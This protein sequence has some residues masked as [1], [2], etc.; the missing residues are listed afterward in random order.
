[1]C[2]VIGSTFEGANVMGVAVA[3]G[4]WSFAVLRYQELDATNWTG[5]RLKGVDF[6][7]ASL[8]KCLFNDAILDGAQPGP[9]QA[10]R[11]RPARR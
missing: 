10:A 8:K 4:D 11:S 9:R 6:T 5:V 7:G 1:M 3:G 2:R